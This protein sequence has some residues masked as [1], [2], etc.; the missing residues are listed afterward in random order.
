MRGR[1]ASAALGAGIARRRAQGEMDD[2]AQMYENQQQ[3]YQRQIDEQR[4]QIE[5]LQQQKQHP[6]Q[7]QEDPTQKLKK[8]AD[9]KQQGVITEE[10]FQKLK[11]DLLSK[12]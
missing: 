4:R 10:E 8:Y 5:A 1:W 3:Q 6:Q 11:A 12:I 9:L 2:Q 7:Q